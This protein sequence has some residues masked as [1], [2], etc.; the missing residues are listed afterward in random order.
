MTDDLQPRNSAPET[1]AT[2]LPDTLQSLGFTFGEESP[3]TQPVE[4]SLDVTPAAPAPL[5]RRALREAEK[6]ASRR[7]GRSANRADRRAEV[8]AHASAATAAPASPP[9]PANPADIATAPLEAVD[10]PAVEP[11]AVVGPVHPASSRGRRSVAPR[12]PASLPTATAGAP[13]RTRLGKRVAQKTFPPIVMAAAAALLIGTSV[14]PSAL[15]DPDAAPASAAYAAVP[16]N[17]LESTAADAPEPAP[18]MVEDQVL[19]MPATENV[20][21]P[22][23]SRDDWS[24]TSYAEMLRLK[25]GTRNFSYSTN[26]TGAVRWPFPYT[27]P[28]SSGFGD[29]VA[30]CFGCSS[31]HRGLDLVPGR[32]TPVY[33][34][35]DGVVT[36]VGAYTTYG[37]RVEIAH[38]INGQSVESLYA[39]LEWD[40]S[41]LEVGQE[42]P[43]GTFLGTVGSSGLST[44]PH[45]HLEIAIDGIPIDPFAWLTTNAS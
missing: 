18:E 38:V 25:Y 4:V 26:G 43:V 32:G 7:R 44:G 42:I 28:I 5:S 30:P 31:Y 17:E 9:T 3:A 8:R 35:A 24:V 6:A 45:L 11:S 36:G 29:R 13:T 1:D 12:T 22:A 14:H 40:S 39:H 33:S 16:T 27:V 34:I 20:A 23:A 10:D 19:E 21:A 15:F 2:A 37:Y 41:P